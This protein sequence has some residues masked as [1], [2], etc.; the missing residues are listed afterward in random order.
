MLDILEEN[1]I[2]NQNLR[3][4]SFWKW[5]RSLIVNYWHEIPFISLVSCE[6][7]LFNNVSFSLKSY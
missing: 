5:E 4:E 7:D 6:L 2:D 1:I 3:T